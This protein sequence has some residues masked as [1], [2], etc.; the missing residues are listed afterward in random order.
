MFLKDWHNDN[1]IRNKNI[2]HLLY[3]K[4][5]DVAAS[6]LLSSY[7]TSHRSSF[8]SCFITILSTVATPQDPI[9]SHSPPNADGKAVFYKHFPIISLGLDETH[10]SEHLK[11]QHFL[12]DLQQVPTWKLSLQG[13]G[14]L[15]H[16]FPW[17]PA[18]SHKYIWPRSSAQLS[19]NWQG[20]HVP[21]RSPNAPALVAG[22][23]RKKLPTT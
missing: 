17:L 15:K 20:L 21:A 22:H 19:T 14:Y 8:F 5:T 10:T 9:F 23:K 18:G 16:R 3:N 13:T 1:E 4:P 12:Q 6:D 7:N 2:S 11:V